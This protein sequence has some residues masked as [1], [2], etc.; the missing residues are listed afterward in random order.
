MNICSQCL[1]DKT[2]QLILGILK[3]N[4]TLS[5]MTS[6]KTKLVSSIQIYIL[7]MGSM[8]M[9]LLSLWSRGQSWI[10]RWCC[11]SQLWS[12]TSRNLLRKAKTLLWISMKQRH[13]S[14][15]SATLCI[16]SVQKPL[17]P[18]SQA[19]Q[20]KGILWNYLLRCWRTGAGIKVF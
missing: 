3:S 6:S 19:L 17:S 11:Q 1:L 16:I 15:N 5:M 2:R 12:A 10:I 13:S 4:L 18:D 14:M 7:G 8:V 9:L 20:Q